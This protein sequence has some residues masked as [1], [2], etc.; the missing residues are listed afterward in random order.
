MGSQFLYR[1]PDLHTVQIY[2]PMIDQT[3]IPMSLDAIASFTFPPPYFPNYIKRLDKPTISLE[4]MDLEDLILAWNK[5]CRKLR[6]VQLVRTSAWRR[7]FEGDVWCK[8]VVEREEPGMF[9]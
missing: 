4:D 8:R 3:P 5:S 1:L 9:E 2:K 7:A 6:E